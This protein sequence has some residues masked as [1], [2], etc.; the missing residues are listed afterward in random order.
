MKSGDIE[1]LST[2]KEGYSVLKNC[3]SWRIG[4]VNYDDSIS[5]EPKKIERH[6]KTDEAFILSYSKAKLY[7]GKE[8]EKI[9]IQLG[10]V[11]NIKKGVWHALI[12]E[13]NARLFVIENADT[14]ETNTEKI[15]FNRNKK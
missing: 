12:M 1:I 5:G 3:E 8:L 2:E 14:D 6:L 10:K 9:E 11:Y 4:V 7:I 13:K 15:F